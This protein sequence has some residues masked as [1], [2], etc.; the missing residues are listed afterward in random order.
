MS[1]KKI[2]LEPLI[3]IG[4]RKYTEPINIPFQ[5]KPDRQYYCCI[6]ADKDTCDVYECNGVNSYDDSICRTSQVNRSPVSYIN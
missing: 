1:S 5:K 2:K 3:N 4:K 6:H